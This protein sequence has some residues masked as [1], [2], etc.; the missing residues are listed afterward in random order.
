MK[1][2]NLLKRKYM[3]DFLHKYNAFTE[4]EWTMNRHII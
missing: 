3:Y 4:I 2:K 1:N